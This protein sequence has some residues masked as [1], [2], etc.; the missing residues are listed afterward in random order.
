MTIIVIGSVA[1]QG[2]GASVLPGQTRDG[3]DHRHLRAKDRLRGDKDE[4]VA[5][6]EGVGIGLCE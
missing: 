6:G 3:E 4:D 2:F 1:Q 5:A